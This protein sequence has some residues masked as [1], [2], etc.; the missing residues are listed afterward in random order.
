MVG[1]SQL[2][3]LGKYLLSKFDKPV[4]L[5]ETLDDPG[6]ATCMAFDPSSEWI[7]LAK[8]GGS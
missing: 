2:M 4:T 8:A 5:A 6:S 3:G 1:V 7:I